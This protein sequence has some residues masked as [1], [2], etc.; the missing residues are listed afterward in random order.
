[1]TDNNKFIITRSLNAPRELVWKVWTQKDHLMKWFGPKGVTM[2]VCDM[3]LR[4]GGTFLYAME[5][6]DGNRMWGKWV[7]QE[8]I[9]PEKLVLINSFSDENGNITRHPMAPTWPRE[10]LST[11]TLKEADGKT[12]LT[13][14]WLP[15]NAGED[16]ISTFEAGRDSVTGGWAGTFEQLEA[17]LASI[18]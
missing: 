2:P 13:I 15:I 14:E 10:M 6:P 11:T 9:P 12:E 5:T 16:E 18:Q 7:F 3:D 8:I 1:M 17:Y 4:V